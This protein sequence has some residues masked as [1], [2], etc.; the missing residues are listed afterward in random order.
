MRG[1]GLALPCHDGACSVLPAHCTLCRLGNLS[2]SRRLH[3]APFS[4]THLHTLAG[5]PIKLIR[6]SMRHHGGTHHHLWATCL[7]LHAALHALAQY[8]SL[9]EAEGFSGCDATCLAES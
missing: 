6:P 7:L 3:Q 2:C 4:L 9:H 5:S 1:K 8:C